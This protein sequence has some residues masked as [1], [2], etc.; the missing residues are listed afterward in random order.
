MTGEPATGATLRRLAGRLP[1]ACQSRPA[2]ERRDRRDVL[3]RVR[4][5]VAV[6]LAICGCIGA[7]G[8]GNVASALPQRRTNAAK[9]RGAGIV[10]DLG[11]VLN[12]RVLRLYAVTVCRFIWRV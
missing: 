7:H 8:P 5:Q 3:C 9:H 6:A 1:L 2:G 4:R 11:A 12:R 10:A